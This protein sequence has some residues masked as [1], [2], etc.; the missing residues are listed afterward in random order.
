MSRKVKREI[1]MIKNSTTPESGNQAYFSLWSLSS[2]LRSHSIYA[3]S[4]GMLSFILEV[5]GREI[6]TRDLV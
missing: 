6:V 1:E 5:V 3:Y 2:A 4:W